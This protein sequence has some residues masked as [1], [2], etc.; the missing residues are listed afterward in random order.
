MFVEKISVNGRGTIFRII[1]GKEIYWWSFTANGHGRGGDIHDGRQ[2]NVVIKGKFLV[3]M[4]YPEEGE[5]E[6]VLLEGDSIVIPNDI[7][8]VFIA[9]EDSW[10]LEWH[11]HKLPPFKDKRYYEPYRKLV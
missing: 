6:R 3:K 7:P 10:M 9:L 2:Y 1:V 8:H 11:D 5:V 4:M